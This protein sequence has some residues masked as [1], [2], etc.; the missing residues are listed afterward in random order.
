VDANSRTHVRPAFLN[1]ARHRSA[2]QSRFHYTDQSLGSPLSYE[3]YPL[4]LS[5]KFSSSV[6]SPGSSR[7]ENPLEPCD[8][9]GSRKVPLDLQMHPFRNGGPPI[10]QTNRVPAY[11]F[12]VSRHQTNS[13]SARPNHYDLFLETE[14]CLWTWEWLDLPATCP[15][16]W[17]RRLPNHRKV[18]LDHSG[19]ISGDR[20]TLTPFLRGHL[21]WKEVTEAFVEVDLF[22]PEGEWTLQLSL[23]QPVRSGIPEPLTGAVWEENLPSWRYLWTNRLR[24]MDSKDGK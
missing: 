11:R 22:A 3:P 4:P 13:A 2:P 9:G 1:A 17:C 12:S 10:F 6:N 19:P 18:Y 14:D 16:G 21:V 5:L 20:G 23:C 24:A 7:Y 15:K 8:S